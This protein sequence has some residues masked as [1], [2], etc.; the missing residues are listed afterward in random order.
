M[1]EVTLETI[2]FCEEKN[3]FCQVASLNCVHT[4]SGFCHVDN[5]N[6]KLEIRELV[7]LPHEIIIFSLDSFSFSS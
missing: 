1:S 2:T 7:S 4:W 5:Q 3:T 6:K